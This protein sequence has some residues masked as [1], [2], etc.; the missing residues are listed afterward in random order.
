LRQWLSVRFPSI[1]PLFP[2]FTARPSSGSTLE[3][4][5][6]GE[7]IASRFLRKQGFKVLYRNYKPRNGGE[8]DLVCR[9]REVLVFVEV[10][11]R[12]SEEFGTPAQAVTQEQQRRIS[13]G[14]LEW[15]RML[16][17]PQ[18]SFRFDIVEVLSESSEPVCRLVKN[19]FPLSAPFR[20]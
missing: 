4:G 14:A 20:Y 7:T 5:R 17:N 12:A 8:I 2:F 3:R 19:A 11:T 6:W 13:K 10:K 16:G 9:D 18:I 15:L 1:K